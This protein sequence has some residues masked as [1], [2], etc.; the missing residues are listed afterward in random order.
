MASLFS[1]PALSCLV[2]QMLSYSYASFSNNGIYDKCSL[3]AVLDMR[4]SQLETRLR[5]MENKSDDSV[6]QPVTG[7]DCTSIAP[8]VTPQ[9]PEYVS[10]NESAPPR[11][12]NTYIPQ[13][14]G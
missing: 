2:C 8:P 1:S 14:T 5:A 7:A 12:N 13:D 10:L 3:F 9:A 6:S 11:Y 4:L